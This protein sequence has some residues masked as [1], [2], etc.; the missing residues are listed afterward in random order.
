MDSH[1]LTSYT[2]QS[3]WYAQNVNGETVTKVRLMPSWKCWCGYG[4]G[5]HYPDIDL[6]KKLVEAHVSCYV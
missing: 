6:V 2:L 3:V 4:N 5:C 1:R